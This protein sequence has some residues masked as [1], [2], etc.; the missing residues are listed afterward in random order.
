MDR[1]GGGAGGGTAGTPTDVQGWKGWGS[2]TAGSPAGVREGR[3][4]SV[5]SPIGTLGGK[6]G[7]EGHRGPCLRL[8]TPSPWDAPRLTRHLR[9]DRALPS[10]ASYS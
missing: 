1:G 8:Y 7:G 2:R 6:E 9:G 5:G 4:R 3:E 10:G